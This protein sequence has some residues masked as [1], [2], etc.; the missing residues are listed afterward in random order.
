MP[1]ETIGEKQSERYRRNLRLF[2]ICALVCAASVSCAIAPGR[3]SAGN[4]GK[5]R[6]DSEIRAVIDAQQ[7]AWNQGDVDG[8]MNG[9]DRSP[10]TVFVSGDT[11]TR[12]WQT[13][14]DRYRKKYANAAQMGR[15]TFSDLEITPLS[16][17]LATVLGR[18]ELARKG[19]H[20]H[21]RFTLLFHRTP[22]GWRIVQDHTS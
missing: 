22:A 1:G 13:V 19:D 12:G 18:W 17:D 6:S 2:S 3:I 21:G 20:P 5:T 7:K 4:E 14:R 9:Y 16:R 10:A 11:V 8:F 15:L